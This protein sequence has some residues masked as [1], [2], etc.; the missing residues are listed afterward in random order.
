MNEHDLKRI[1]QNV[2]NLVYLGDDF[3][4]SSRLSTQNL[5][6]SRSYQKDLSACCVTWNGVQLSRWEAPTPP[7]PHAAVLLLKIERFVP[8]AARGAADGRAKP[9]AGCQA[10][11][12]CHS[13]SGIAFLTTSAGC[14]CKIETRKLRCVSVL[15]PKGADWCP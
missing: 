14:V 5:A 2:S 11:L 3:Q 15:T 8:I 6:P 9:G 10:M 7:L 4:T 12:L 1:L 13:G